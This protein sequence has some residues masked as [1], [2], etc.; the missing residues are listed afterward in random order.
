MLLLEVSLAVIRSRKCLP[1]VRIVTGKRALAVDGV[2]MA[3]KIF[4]ETES[5]SVVAA[6]SSA[7][8]GTFVSLCVLSVKMLTLGHP[9]IKCYTYLRSQRRVNTL[10]QESQIC[11][12]FRRIRGAGRLSVASIELPCVGDSGA[13]LASCLRLIE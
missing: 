11:G 5:L 3:P 7:L 12:G 13:G 10:P 2:Y 1:T 6:G 9:L 4:L 8:E